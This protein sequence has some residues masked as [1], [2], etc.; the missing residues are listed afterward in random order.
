MFHCLV[1]DLKH[2]SMVELWFY[3]CIYLS[4]LLIYNFEVPL[5]DLHDFDADVVNIFYDVVLTW[6]FFEVI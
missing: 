3:L 5:E 6:E 2:S 1:T 4:V